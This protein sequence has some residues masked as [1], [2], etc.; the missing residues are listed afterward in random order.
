MNL[1]KQ[2]IISYIKNNLDNKVEIYWIIAVGAGL[3]VAIVSYFLPLPQ[4]DATLY[5][6]S[7]ISQGLAAIFTLIFTIT[8]FGSQMM[9]KFT[10][11]DK[12]IDNKW[13]IILMIIFS[14][15]II[16]PMMQLRTDEDLLHLNLLDTAQ[17]SLSIDLGIATFCVLAII[18]YLMRVNRIMKYEGGVSILNNEISEAFYSNQELKASNNVKEL[19]E[20]CIS[21]AD[22]MLEDKTIEIID[23]LREIGLKAIDKGWRDTAQK[24]KDELEKIGMKTTEKELDGKDHIYSPIKKVLMALK[25]IEVEA[26]DTKLKHW[27]MDITKSTIE[28]LS[29][30]GVQSIDRDLSK[31]TISE[32]LLGLSEIG[33]RVAKIPYMIDIVL[34]GLERIADQAYKKDSDKFENPIEDSLK[35]LW[36]ICSFEM[37]Y[38][39]DY[40]T[41]NIYRLKASNNQV[42]KDFGSKKI[43]S[44][45]LEYILEY[46]YKT[47]ELIEDEFK[48]CELLYDATIK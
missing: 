11:M 23:N 46:D 43:R 24:S 10:A 33:V 41:E 17:L 9:R 28:R 32:A 1:T 16:L 8:I 19:A 36:V 42:I 7:T 15:G 35:F 25:E 3:L 34:D 39:P 37:K 44:K 31:S 21:S 47:D 13:A 20:L 40:A 48:K 6:L 22:E 18:P 12:M 29:E 5:L 26:M 2:K 38:W 27:K 4:I 45:A 14:I 30:I